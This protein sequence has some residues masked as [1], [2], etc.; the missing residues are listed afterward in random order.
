[1]EQKHCR[2]AWLLVFWQGVIQWEIVTCHMKKT[3]IWSSSESLAIQWYNCYDPETSDWLR[4]TASLDCLQLDILS[5][6]ET[7]QPFIGDRLWP[8]LKLSNDLHPFNCVATEQTTTNTIWGTL[9]NQ[10]VCIT[11]TEMSKWIRLIKQY[12]RWVTEEPV[13]WHL[14]QERCD[15]LKCFVTETLWHYNA[16]T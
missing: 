2:S 8:S 4:N 1:M 15:L 12:N 7:R 14:W 5:S 11:R 9:G 3:K 10:Y 13:L 6:C 16:L